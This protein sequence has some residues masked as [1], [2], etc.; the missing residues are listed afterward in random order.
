VE[1][2]DG[3]KINRIRVDGIFSLPFKFVYNPL[4][5]LFFFIRALRERA[6]VYHC[7]YMLLPAI[8]LKIVRKKV[9]LD[10]GDDTL[11]ITLMQH[12]LITI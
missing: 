12:V 10:I 11:L 7:E 4:V 2:I 1:Y 9:I 5:Y 3:I 8:M 6:S